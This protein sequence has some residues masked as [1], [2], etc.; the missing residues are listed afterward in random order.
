MR[1][2]KELAAVPFLVF[3]PVFALCLVG[4]CISAMLGHAPEP[5]A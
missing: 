5:L 2:V 3:L 4:V 1:F